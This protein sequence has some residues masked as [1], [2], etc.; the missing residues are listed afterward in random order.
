MRAQQQKM[1][2]MRAR[3]QAFTKA[4]HRMLLATLANQRAS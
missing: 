3:H 2:V 4:H 1:R